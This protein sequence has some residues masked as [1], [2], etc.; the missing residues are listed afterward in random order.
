MVIKD[1]LMVFMRF[2][3]HCKREGEGTQM[4]NERAELADEDLRKLELRNAE[5]LQRCSSEA[6]GALEADRQKAGLWLTL[7]VG[8][9]MLLGVGALH[10]VSVRTG[11]AQ[12]LHYTKPPNVENGAK[13][14]KGGCIAC[15]GADGKGAPKASTVFVRPDTFPDF[16]DCAGTTPEPNGN[17]KA[18]IVH[19]GP[20]RGLSQIMPAFG[21]L[22][23]DE[24]INDVIAYMRGF[25]KNTHHDPLGELNLPRALVTEKAFPEKELV[26]STAAS[27]S[28]RRPGQR[29]SSMS[30]RSSMRARSWRPMFR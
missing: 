6:P 7:L 4:C 23:T 18:V 29:T 8:G 1:G 11:W 3:N 25:C 13:V 17:W 28:A 20:S 16:T 26:V 12:A 5:L 24:Q 22:L 19:G 14:Y 15:H 9:G 27:A 30:G 2:R 10:H 21:D